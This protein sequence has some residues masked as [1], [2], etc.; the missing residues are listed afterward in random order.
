LG[1]LLPELTKPWSRLQLH[2]QKG[3]LT[4]KRNQRQN[5]SNPGAEKIRHAQTEKNPPALTHEE[6]RDRDRPQIQN[7]IK[8]PT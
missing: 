4:K 7:N 1:K 6:T 2:K 5:E 3:K 8:E